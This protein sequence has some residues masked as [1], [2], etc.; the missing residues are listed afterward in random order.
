VR[1]FSEIRSHVNTVVGRGSILRAFSSGF[2]GT[3]A[4]GPPTHPAPS[5]APATVV[6]PTI[7]PLDVRVQSLSDSP[8]PAR[9]RARVH[10]M[11][12]AAEAAETSSDSNSTLRAAILR[13][14]AASQH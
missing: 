9:A 1:D 2:D 7:P 14:R 4:A 5:Q 12:T 3:P 8:A 6:P 11:P 13:R 10:A